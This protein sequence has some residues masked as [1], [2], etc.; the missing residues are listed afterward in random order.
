MS[1][2]NPK[3]YTLQHK[4]AYLV[5]ISYCYTCKVLK[6]FNVLVTWIC[7]GIC[8]EE[9]RSF[10]NILLRT[11]KEI[12]RGACISSR[13]GV[14]RIMNSQ[15]LNKLVILRMS[16][17]ATGQSQKGH[18]KTVRTSLGGL[19]GGCAPDSSSFHGAPTKLPTVVSC[20]VQ[21]VCRSV[22]IKRYLPSCLSD[23]GEL[24]P[25]RSS[26]QHPRSPCS[27]IASASPHHRAGL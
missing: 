25:L 1:T 4:K 19:G 2:K 6:I 14:L 21:D 13:K 16:Q 5:S 24:S 17:L 22:C 18:T 3:K 12:W 11:G 8:G 9:P 23:A 26:E 7:E 27:T 10:M 20:Y 15:D